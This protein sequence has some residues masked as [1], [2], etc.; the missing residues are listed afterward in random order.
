MLLRH[1]IRSNY[2]I[3]RYYG[4]YR[5]KHK[6]HDTIESITKKYNITVNELKEYNTF[7]NLELNMKLIIPNEEL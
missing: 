3:I 2:K 4:F 7:D 6:L 5:K 1:L